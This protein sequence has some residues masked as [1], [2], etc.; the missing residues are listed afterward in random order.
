MTFVIPVQTLY[1]WATRPE[2]SLVSCKFYY[3]RQVMNN[4]YYDNV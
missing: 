1:H 2:G 4:N 3:T